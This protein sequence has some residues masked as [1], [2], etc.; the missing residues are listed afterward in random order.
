MHM[1][2]DRQTSRTD[3]RGRIEK[4]NTTVSPD[5]YGETGAT[6]ATRT[7]STS[8]A[9]PLSR[10]LTIWAP[11]KVKTLKAKVA[12]DAVCEIIEKMEGYS[13]ELHRKRGVA[14]ATSRRQSTDLPGMVKGKR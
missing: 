5:H 12:S 7:T 13:S 8:C 9:S 3:K 4:Y 6:L 14:G 2:S 1:T 10:Y 11:M